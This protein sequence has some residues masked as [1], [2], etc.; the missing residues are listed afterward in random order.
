MQ[1]RPDSYWT[2]NNIIKEYEADY[3]FNRVPHALPVQ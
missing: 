1:S 2:G 3:T